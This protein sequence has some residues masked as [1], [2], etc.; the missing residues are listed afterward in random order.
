MPV[1]KLGTSMRRVS[2]PRATTPGPIWG[3]RPRSSTGSRP[4][5]RSSRSSSAGRM[6]SRQSWVPL[7]TM[8]STCSS[9]NTAVNH[10]QGVRLTVSN[11]KLPP[12]A[13]TL[14][15]SATAAGRSGRCSSTSAATT[16]SKLPSANGSR[17]SRPWAGRNGAADGPAGHPEAAQRAVHPDHLGPGRGQLAGHQAAAAAGV[18]HQPAAQV[19][20]LPQVEVDP[21][22]VDGVQDRRRAGRVPPQLV[23]GLVVLVVDRAPRR[24]HRPGPV[25]GERRRSQLGPP[26]ALAVPSSTRPSHCRVASWEG[27][28]SRPALASR[29]SRSS[30]PVRR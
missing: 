12:G 8:R 4:A 20:E 6:N 10:D 26:G 5:P 2:S 27:G 9:P 15:S 28:S 24:R 17:S 1:A 23:H 11:R 13:S 29:S 22:P 7:G 19:A 25:D 21:G 3:A 30:G 14:A 16:A 18:Q